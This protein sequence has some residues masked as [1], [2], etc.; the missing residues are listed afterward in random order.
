MAD[1][2]FFQNLKITDFIAER[3]VNCAGVVH[4]GQAADG[5]CTLEGGPPQA[6]CAAAPSPAK[7]KG[8][9]KGQGRKKRHNRCPE[10]SGAQRDSVHGQTWVYLVFWRFFFPPV[11]QHALAEDRVNLVEN[12]GH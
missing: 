3:D 9:D 5:C 10:R 6:P 7:G 2:E 8:K 4:L 11:L 12:T 1:P